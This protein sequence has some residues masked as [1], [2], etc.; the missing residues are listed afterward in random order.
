VLVGE[1]A[2]IFGFNSST[3]MAV[4]TVN[5]QQLWNCVKASHMM[6][7]HNVCSRA[8]ALLFDIICVN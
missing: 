8:C 2:F 3:Q 6:T 1:T 7:V 5:G 4:I